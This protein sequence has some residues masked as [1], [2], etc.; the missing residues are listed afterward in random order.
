M[1]KTIQIRKAQDD[2]Y[3]ELMLIENQIWTNENSPILHHYNDVEEYA[4]KQKDELI[5]VA[6]QEEQL[7]GFVNVHQ[8]T[9][10]PSHKHQWMIGIGVH[11]DYQSSGAGRKLL[12]YL[13]MTAPSYGIHKLSLRVMG[14]NNR[15]INFYKRNGFVEEGHLRDEF[16]IN[17]AYC[18]DYLFAYFLQ[19]TEK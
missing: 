8:P 3:S 7:I 17:D 16:Y 4:A 19:K 10:L 5:F 2:D 9:H 12:D 15:A 13:K 18:D 14:T 1:A 6:V 11:P